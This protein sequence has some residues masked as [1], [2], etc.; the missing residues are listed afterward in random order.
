MKKLALSF[1][2]L[3]LSVFAINT[4]SKAQTAQGPAISFDKEVHDYGTV[5][6]NGNGECEFKFTNTGN[7]PL[8]ISDAKGSCGCTVPEWP[9]DPIKP[10]ASAVI[11][12]KYDTK[13]VG[14]INKSVTVTSNA[15]NEGVKTLRIKGTVEAVE[16]GGAPVKTEG[17][18]AP[19]EK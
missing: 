7:A 19:V 17:G 5:K 16:G 13:R 18:G 10:G 12:V 4:E 6:Q 3:F 15:V 14:P 2:V 9:K 1:G 11:K 8:I